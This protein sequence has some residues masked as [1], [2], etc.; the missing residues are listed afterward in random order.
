MRTRSEKTLEILEAAK[1]LLDPERPMTLRH[2]YYLLLS[3]HV[4]EGG[5]AVASNSRCV[6]RYV[7][8]YTEL[9]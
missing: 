6:Q 2:L 4:L 9:A 8:L 3:D 7:E 1:A 5:D